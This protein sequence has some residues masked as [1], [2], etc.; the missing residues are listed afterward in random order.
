[1]GWRRIWNK[2][3]RKARMRALLPSIHN[4]ERMEGFLSPLEAS[5]LCYFASLLPTAAVVVE[6]GSW[7]GK[8]T[9]CLAQ[10]LKSGV[11]NAVDPFD[12]TGSGEDSI[13]YEQRRGQEPL[14]EQFKRNLGQHI[15]SGQV[16][17]CV[18]PS[19]DFVGKFPK[20]DLLFIDGDHSVEGCRFDFQNFTP[21]LAVG[22]YLLFHDYRRWKPETG[23]THV[24]QQHVVPSGQFE[25]LGEFDTLWVGQKTG[26]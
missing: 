24:V 19:R 5:H 8:S 22:G 14:V 4:Y 10:G 3:R 15:Q 26:T 23:P 9:Y 20:I 13:T 2:W 11:I 17:P 12:A 7:K 1:M 18:G 16:V 21:Q 25:W 6:I